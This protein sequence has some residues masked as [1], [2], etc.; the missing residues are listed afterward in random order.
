MRCS[1]PCY[2]SGFVKMMIV[3]G[4]GGKNLYHWYLSRVFNFIVSFIKSQT[5]VTLYMLLSS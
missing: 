4:G 1:K 3:G 5:A 2:R